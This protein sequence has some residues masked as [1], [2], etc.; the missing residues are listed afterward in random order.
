MLRISRL[1]HIS[2]RDPAFQAQHQPLPANALENRRMRRHQP[3][4]LLAHQRT[5]ARHLGQKGIVRDDVDHCRPYGAAQRVAAIGRAMRARDHA[6]SRPFGGQHRPQREA[7]ANALGDHHDVGGDPGPFM[8]KQL[9]GA[10]HAALH[11]VQDHQRARGIAKVAQTLEA[12]IGQHADAAFALDRFQHHR[13]RTAGDRGTQRVVIAE[14]QHAEAGHQRAE[15]LGHLFRPCRRNRPGGPAVEGTLKGHNLDPVRLALI[16]P[17]F[18]GHLDR[19]F[20]GLGAGIGEEDRVGKAMVHQ[21]R[22]QLFLL[23]DAVKVG[24]MPQLRRLRAQ[25]RHQRRMRMAQRVHRD[26]RPQ[27]KVSAAIPGH[28]P[29]AFAPDKRQGRT[30]IGGQDGRDHRRGS[31]HSAPQGCQRQARKSTNVRRG[32]AAGARDRSLTRGRV[33]VGAGNMRTD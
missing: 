10:A 8:G 3:F 32:C 24:H 14:G 19:Q 23:R 16:V 27:I 20:G 18:A 26:A 31:L 13:R 7:A 17:V 5:L 9:A 6:R 2:R 15:A 29:R 4:Q 30:G 12:G 11:L 22:R 1:D 33:G 28:Q 21:Q 25:C